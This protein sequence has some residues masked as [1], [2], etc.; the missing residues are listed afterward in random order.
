MN[1]QPTVI[2]LDAGRIVDAVIIVAP[3]D[4]R[5]TAGIIAGIQTVGVVQ[6]QHP[7]ALKRDVTGAGKAGI[8]PGKGQSILSPAFGIA[9]GLVSDSIHHDRVTLPTDGGAAGT[10]NIHT[11]REGVVIG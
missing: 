2:K 6:R 10:Q 1:T 3:Q 4:R 5:H 9:I 11:T 8:C 7:A